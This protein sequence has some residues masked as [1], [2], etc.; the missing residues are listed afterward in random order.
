MIQI[1]QPPTSR[2]ERAKQEKLIRIKNVARDLFAKQGYEATTVRHI[3][4]AADIAVGTVFTYFKDKSHLLVKLFEE[5]LEITWQKVLTEEPRVSLLENLLSVFTKLLE[6]Y[7]K[8]DR[9]SVSFLREV[10]T[11]DASQGW[12]LQLQNFIGHLASLVQQAQE[13]GEVRRGV[14]LRQA[15]ANFFAL[16]YASLTAML[17]S[18]LTVEVTVTQFLRPALE[19]Q[20]HGLLAKEA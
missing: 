17:S 3:S 18:S 14:D 12:S 19:L 16:Y 2:R 1:V 6:F 15:A 8:D 4:D 20:L 9:L 7:K 11:M 10:L 5:E 13:R